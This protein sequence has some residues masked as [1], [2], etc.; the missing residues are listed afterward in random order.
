MDP[1]VT[2][3]QIAVQL[4]LTDEFRTPNSPLP[5]YLFLHF[6]ELTEHQNINIDPELF[7][8]IWVDEEVRQYYEEIDQFYYWGKFRFK[9][10]FDRVFKRS[11]FK[12]KPEFEN[13]MIKK[14]YA[15][16]RSKSFGKYMD[17]E[18]SF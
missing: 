7:Y 6:C 4:R 17:I 3:S 18:R 14:G 13:R 5:Q 2:E 15:G 16:A 11:L 8:Q 10:T 9:P 12:L 1:W